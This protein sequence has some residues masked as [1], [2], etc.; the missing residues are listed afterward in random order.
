MLSK[1]SNKKLAIIFGILFLFVITIYLTDTGKKERTF[2]ENLVNIDSTAVTEIIIYPKSQNQSE[3]KLFLENDKWKV[4]LSN[5]E[6]SLVPKAKIENLFSQIFSIKPKR[7]AA[8]GIEKW[9]EFEVDS[10][11]TR[12]KVVEDGDVTL[13]ILFGK[14]SFQQPRSMSTYVRLHNDSDIYE[15]DGFLSATFNQGADN[16]RNN[17]IADSDFNTWNQLTFEYPADSS[18]QLVKFNGSWFINNVKTDSTKTDKYFRQIQHL[19][20][21]N[22]IDEFDKTKLDDPSYK[23]SVRDESNE[24]FEVRG[25]QLDSLF[26]VNPSVNEKSFFDGSKLGLKNKVFA[27]SKEFYN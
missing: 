4:H 8:R 15:V 13:D 17:I 18:F 5:D 26:L 21:S 22:F 1:L 3:V 20:S 10:A 2:R 24:L 19:T 16:Y 25:Y 23:L 9:E 11:A 7:L 14:F 12:L 6:I 27:S